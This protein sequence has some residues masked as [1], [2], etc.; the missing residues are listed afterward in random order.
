LSAAGGSIVAPNVSGVQFIGLVSDTPF[1]TLE[2]SG[3]FRT[4]GDGF[5]FDN[6]AFSS[7]IPEPATWAMM[8][9]G[10]GLVGG[11]L[12]RTN[13]RQHQSARVTYA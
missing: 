1:T 5:G 3:T 2:L 10:F 9:L 12:R 13:N 8:I 7:A 6:L 4:G 11:S